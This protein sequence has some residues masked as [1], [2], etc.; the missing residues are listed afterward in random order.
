MSPNVTNVTQMPG[1]QEI[2]SAPHPMHKYTLWTVYLFSFPLSPF[3]KMKV[4]LLR[5]QRGSLTAS[6]SLFDD[7]KEA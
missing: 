4:P 3:D 1:G 5:C 6:L 2:N 7:P